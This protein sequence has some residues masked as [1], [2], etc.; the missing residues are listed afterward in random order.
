MTQRRNPFEEVERF[1]ERM[2][3]QFEDSSAVWEANGPLGW[4][5][6]FVEMPVD[7]A[8]QDEEF[9]VTVDLPGFDKDDVDVRVTDHTLRIEA[10]HEEQT[11]EESPE[12]LR[13]ERR[14]ESM[15]R[16]I[17]L[18]EEVEKTGVKAKMTNGV[19]TVTVPKLEVEEAQTIE[20]E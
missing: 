15:Y 3:R 13:Q 16:S 20:I 4:G 17:K 11:D 2:S 10:E 7:L 18:P 12:Y 19:L 5:G 8:E 6:G 1:F 9:I 14:H